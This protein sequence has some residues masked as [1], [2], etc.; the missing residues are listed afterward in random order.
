MGRKIRYSF[1]FQQKVVSEI[2]SGKYTSYQAAKIYDIG[3]LV[4]IYNWIEKLGKAKL[5]NKVV[6]VEVSDELD[7]LKELEKK[8]KELESALAQAHI[9]MIY[10]DKLISIVE[11]RTGVNWRKKYEKKGQDKRWN[12]VRV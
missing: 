4:T 9:K 7:R 1:A 10:Q 3:S 11:E 12:L 8:N 6:R 5:L 2:E